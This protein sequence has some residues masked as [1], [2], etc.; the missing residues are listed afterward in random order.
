[1]LLECRPLGKLRCKLFSERANLLHK[2]LLQLDCTG[3]NGVEIIAP[4]QVNALDDWLADLCRDVHALPFAIVI[5][6]RLMT[7]PMQVG[8][9]TIMACLTAQC[10]LAALYC[11]PQSIA[12]LRSTGRKLPLALLGEVAELP[13]QILNHGIELLAE[14]CI[15]VLCSLKVRQSCFHDTQCGARFVDDCF[16][17]KGLAADHSIDDVSLQDWHLSVVLRQIRLWKC[18]LQANAASVITGRHGVHWNLRMFLLHQLLHHVVA[19]HCR[20]LTSGAH[21]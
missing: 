10:P 11:T 5:H 13:P 7:P 15:I 20:T 9:H 14:C 16:L 17:R 2:L 21:R 8:P 19:L 18:V 12:Q 1:M 6:Q 4:T 3:D